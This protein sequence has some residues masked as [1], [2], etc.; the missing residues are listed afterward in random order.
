MAKLREK[1][2]N[3]ALDAVSHP[4]SEA[5]QGAAKVQQTAAATAPP[6]Q[7][8]ELTAQDWF[9]RG[10]SATSVEEK[11][12]CYGEAIRL[13]PDDAAAYYNRGIARCD[14][15]DLDGAKMDFAE[16]RR[17]SGE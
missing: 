2:L 3:V 10:Y 5:A 17:L 6:V 4:P 11:L 1:F 14:K 7:E 13:K 16:A 8:K 12:R 9:E 15:G